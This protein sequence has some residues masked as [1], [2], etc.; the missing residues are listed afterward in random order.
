MHVET[1]A[2]THNLRVIQESY[3]I[4]NNPRGGGGE[5]REREREKEII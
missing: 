4:K 3:Q 1:F 5:G 2:T